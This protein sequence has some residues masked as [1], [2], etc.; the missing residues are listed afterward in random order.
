MSA[1]DPNTGRGSIPVV[2]MDVL[3]DMLNSALEWETDHVDDGSTTTGL[4]QVPSGL[5]CPKTGEQSE[6]ESESDELP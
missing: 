2:L 6:F 4:T 5:N 3:T 1:K